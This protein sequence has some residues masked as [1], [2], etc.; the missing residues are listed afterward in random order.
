[1]VA[2]PRIAMVTLKNR[3]FE[4]AICFR[5]CVERLGPTDPKTIQAG[6][7]LLDRVEHIHKVFLPDG[8]DHNTGATVLRTE[9]VHG[10]DPDTL[11]TRFA[12][13]AEADKS[14]AKQQAEEDASMPSAAQAQA[15]ADGWVV[16]E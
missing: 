14:L 2:T 4:A 5:E 13:E 16:G 10:W 11:L 3:L 8:R 15:A 1:M 6:Q 12:R 9:S 7:H